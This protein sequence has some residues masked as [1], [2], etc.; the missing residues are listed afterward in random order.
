M[1]IPAYSLCGLNA[2]WMVQYRAVHGKFKGQRCTCGKM[3]LARIGGDEFVAILIDLE[4][5]DACTP[6]L[7][8]LREAAAAPVQ[9]GD[10][11]VE[12]SASLGVTFYP[13]DDD[14][15]ADQ[16]LRQSDQAMYIPG[17]GGGKESLSDL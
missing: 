6:L 17:K 7:N 1:P 12:V 8:R 9:L 4:S 10:I 5:Q 11:A 2:E 3:P 16:L 14:M 15:Y 13:Q